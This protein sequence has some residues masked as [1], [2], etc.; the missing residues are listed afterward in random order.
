MLEGAS[1]LSLPGPGS[2]VLPPGEGAHTAMS[3]LL[4][5]A[6]WV[7]CHDSSAHTR[8]LQACT[9]RTLV[10][11]VKD[12]PAGRFTLSKREFLETVIPNQLHRRLTYTCTISLSTHAY[13][14]TSVVLHT[15]AH[16]HPVFGEYLTPTTYSQIL[17]MSFRYS[18]IHL[19]TVG[20]TPTH[21]TLICLYLHK[22]TQPPRHTEESTTTL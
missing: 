19:L 6:H 20:H 4:G 9:H 3:P 17:L 10:H 8:N 16:T 1:A 12:A 13:T 14:H 21:N 18:E 7:T 11:W 2:F 5:S 22:S 15:C